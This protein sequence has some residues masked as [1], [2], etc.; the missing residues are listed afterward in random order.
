MS[1]TVEPPETHSV[2]RP[3]TSI[4]QQSLEQPVVVPQQQ[5]QSADSA[6]LLT[7]LQLTLQEVNGLK[8]QLKQL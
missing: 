5:L 2:A 8:Q 6:A 4:H 7:Q 3:T 1:S